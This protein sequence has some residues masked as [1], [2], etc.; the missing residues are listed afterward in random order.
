MRAGEVIVGKFRIEK[1]LGAGGMGVVVAAH[2]M[3]PD[4]KS[5]NLWWLRE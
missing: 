4:D 3:Q 1:L 2:R 5:L